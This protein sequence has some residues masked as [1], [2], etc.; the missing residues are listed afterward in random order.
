[1]D[2]NPPFLPQASSQQ[3][4]N[5]IPTKS[6]ITIWNS[7]A[8]D[9]EVNKLQSVGFPATPLSVPLPEGYNGSL[10]SHTIY[11]L[12]SA[13]TYKVQF[14]SNGGCGPAAQ[15]TLSCE[16]CLIVPGNKIHTFVPCTLHISIQHTGGM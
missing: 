2:L 7:T 16:N 6:V 10:I 5:G 12:S 1:M 3:V 15:G 11:N 14:C 13:V 8:S 4:W 9:A